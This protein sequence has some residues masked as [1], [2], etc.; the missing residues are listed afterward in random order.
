MKLDRMIAVRTN[1]TVWRD[2]DMCLKVFDRTYSRAGV[3]SEAL[4]LA[5]VAEI[6][7]RVPELREVRPI[8]GCF[9]IITDY[10]P[11]KTLDRLMREDPGQ[12]ARYMKLFVKTQ[13]SVQEKTCPPLVKLRDRIRRKLPLTDLEATLRY[14]LISRLEAMPQ[15]ERLCHG[16]FEPENLILGEDGEIWILDWSRASQGNPEA[17]AAK[18]W[19]RFM[20][21][22]D[23][24]GAD[25]YV[26]VWSGMT[27]KSADAVHEWIPII[28]AA[29]AMDGYMSER[30]FC[31][32]IARNYRFSK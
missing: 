18:T 27:G 14:D 3:L 12:R 6:G 15:T 20:I 19:L 31:H 1:K 25:D 24:A 10:I 16:D 2:G 23:P 29:E 4:N 30:A 22:G 5:R 13:L 17:D 28:A 21:N 26:R 32:E 8:D 7:V 11:G 9:T